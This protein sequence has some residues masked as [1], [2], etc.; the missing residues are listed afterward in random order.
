M[1]CAGVIAIA[2]GRDIFRP[3][4][5]R[6]AE[7]LVGIQ[8]GP[9]DPGDTMLNMY[10][11]ATWPK[12]CQTIGV[13]FEPY[14]PVVMPL[15][16]RTATTDAENK[17]PRARSFLS[18]GDDEQSQALRSLVVYC[19]TLQARF[20]PYVMQSLELTLST[21]RL[22]SHDGIQESCI[23]LVPMLLSCS[24]ASSTLTAQI[25]T[26]TFHELINCIGFE[27]E[28][29]FL[30]KLL[31]CF[32]KSL[33]IVGGPNALSEDLHN[34]ATEAIKYQLDIIAD[35]RKNRSQQSVPEQV[36]DLIFK[37]VDFGALDDDMETFAIEDMERFLRY[38][39]PNHPLL[40]AV[41]SVRA[42]GRRRGINLGAIDDLVSRLKNIYPVPAGNL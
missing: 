34:G 26:V 37:T 6:L 28:S 8:N 21:L 30:K 17:V 9:P 3:D 42:L 20:A 19:S 32:I 40:V 2:V 1:E 4:A 18:P 38:L 29:L 36:D 13:E 10:L 39:N 27:T 35:K 7:L 5:S 25:V 23:S 22:H 33:K 41:A 24:A 16:I 12:I 15:L 31:K 11:M 14:L